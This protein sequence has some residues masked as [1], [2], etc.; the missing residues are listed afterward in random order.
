MSETPA[1]ATETEA[2]A[3]TDEQA[4]ETKPTE[5]VEFWKSKARE[6]EKRAKENSTA[7]TRL[8]ELEAAN[9]SELEKAQKAAQEAASKLTEVETTNLRMKVALAAGLPLEDVGRIQG[10][11]EEELLE[12]AKSLAARLGKASATPKPDPSQGARGGNQSPST[13]D[14]FA[15]YFRNHLSER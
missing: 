6:Q 4:P 1:E 5:T 12:D 13:A 11:T 15:E 3:S 14:S 9:L 8:K 10:A 7:A 2:T